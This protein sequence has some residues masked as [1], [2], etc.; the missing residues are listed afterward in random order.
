MICLEATDAIPRDEINL[1]GGNSTSASFGKKHEQVSTS[2][3][4]RWLSHLCIP[5]NCSVKLE[6]RRPVRM[7]KAEGGIC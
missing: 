2:Y 7:R 3:L 1:P 4:F 5:W 6:P